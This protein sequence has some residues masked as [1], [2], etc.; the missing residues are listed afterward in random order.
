MSLEISLTGLTKLLSPII[1][2]LIKGGATIIKEKKLEWDANSSTTKLSKLII[3]INTVKTIWS[4]DKDILIDDFYY[5]S[6]VTSRYSAS[7]ISPSELI[8]NNV[9]IQGIVGQGKSI[10]MRKLCNTALEE[11]LIPFFIEL[12]MISAERPLL[13]LLMDFMIAAGIQGDND[14][15]KYLAEKNKIVLI[16]DGFDE[17]SSEMVSG[18]IYQISQLQRAHED[19]KIIISSRPSQITES[20]SGFDV[21]RLQELVEDDYEPFLRKLIPDSLV[22][23]DINLA[24]AGAPNNIKGVMTTPL[25]LTLLLIVYQFET[26]IPATLP[27]FFEKLFNAVFVQHDGY[28]PGFVRERHSGL[29]AS[30]LQKL[31]DAFCFMAL[32]R[33]T[34]RT[35]T[36]KQFNEVFDKAVKYTPASKCEVEGFKA[37]IVKVTCL[38]LDDGFDQVSFLHKSI[39]EYH[40]ASFITNSNNELATTFY[41]IVAEDFDRWS[42][43][44]NFLSYI[45]EFRYGEYYILKEYPDS[46][47]RLSSTLQERTPEALESYLNIEL[48]NL[49]IYMSYGDNPSCSC[50]TPEKQHE[51]MNFLLGNFAMHIRS[52]SK[53]SLNA[54]FDKVRKEKRERQDK[55]GNIGSKLI[56]RHFDMNDFWLKLGELEGELTEVIAKYKKIVEVEKNKHEIFD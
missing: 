22:R 40:A 1:T 20:L 51:F 53:D 12:R 46:L 28:K 8:S 56:A 19:L 13:K 34:N 17:I 41:S 36:K 2:S 27:D 4:R 48:P 6:R 14:I 37:D 16:L 31:F 30:K 32:Q 11:E 52:L 39:M 9:V 23:H 35:L 21:L 29:S 18:T 24:I 54:S 5:P 15:F 44:L 49:E 50:R 43:T 26:E 33:D 10:F 25:M 7:V 47:S 42:E 3:K 55:T 45:D 38:M